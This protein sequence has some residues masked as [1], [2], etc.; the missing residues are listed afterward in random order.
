MLGR[1]RAKVTVMGLGRF[2]GGA[3]A[4]CFWA[5]LGSTVTVTDLRTGAELSDS[6]EA[7]R[8]ISCRYVLGRHEEED[9][10]RADVVVVNPA[11][12]PGN[13]F[14]ELARKHGARIITEI[15]TVLRLLHGPTFGVTGS[16]GKSTTTSLLGA[17]LKAADPDTLVGGN[18][19]GSLLSEI[20]THPPSSPVVMEFSSFQLYYLGSQKMSPHVAVV[21]NLAPNHLDWH[22]SV[23]AYYAAKENLLRFQSPEDV[24]VL[25]AADPVLR[26]WGG[27]TLGRTV[28][29]APDDPDTPNAAFVRDGGVV[30]RLGGREAHAFALREM[31]LPGP[32][33][34]MNAL[35]AAAAAY[36]Q[37]HETRPRA[38]G[39]ANFA[40]LPHRLELVAAVQGVRYYNDSDATTP[41][42]AM[43]ALRSFDCPR[44]LIAGGSDKGASFAELGRAIAREAHRAVLFGKTAPALRAAVEAAGGGGRVETARDLADAVARAREGCPEGGVVL[45]SPAC[46]SFDMFTDYEARGERFREIVMRLERENRNE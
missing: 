26:E 41:E 36:A 7:L 34:L 6:L 19:G 43:A 9:F 32:H 33:N 4:A 40:G 18:I 3:G 45:L 23:E 11:V 8:G 20:P 24:A 21:T 42:S 28:F 39:V 14:V 29:Y 22:G 13:P 25:N 1:E 46:A 38:E 30:V 37:L 15:G 31:R 17:M 12:K 35:A 44:V 16:N 2:G 27:K 10:R 5:G